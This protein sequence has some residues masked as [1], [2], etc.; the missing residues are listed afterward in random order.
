MYKFVAFFANNEQIP[1]N[2]VTAIFK[3][4]NVMSSYRL[5]RTHL[6]F[7]PK[8]DPL[9]SLECDPTGYSMHRIG[10]FHASQPQKQISFLWNACQLIELRPELVQDSVKVM[11]RCEFCA[12]EKFGVYPPFGGITT[13]NL[14]KCDYLDNLSRRESFLLKLN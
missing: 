12:L 2:V 5:A 7:T 9:V 14:H 3:Q 10:H 4:N 1:C 6:A 8:F 13:R 11:S